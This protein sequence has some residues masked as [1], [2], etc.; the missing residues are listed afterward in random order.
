MDY[1]VTVW[2]VFKRFF[3][4]WLIAGVGLV[5]VSCVKHGA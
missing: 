2:I 1:D 5:I 3:L 4:G